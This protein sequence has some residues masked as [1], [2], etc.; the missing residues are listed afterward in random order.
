M[1]APTILR[2]PIEAIQYNPTTNGRFLLASLS[3]PTPL[4]RNIIR[5]TGDPGQRRH[6][7]ELRSRLSPAVV[8]ALLVLGRQSEELGQLYRVDAAFTSG[9]FPNREETVIAARERIHSLRQTYGSVPLR[10]EGL[11]GYVERSDSQEGV[12]CLIS[13]SNYWEGPFSWRLFLYG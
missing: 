7:P 12:N 1:E 8:I 13:S 10:W 2:P 9:N 5:P 3:A 11:P 4:H 6:S